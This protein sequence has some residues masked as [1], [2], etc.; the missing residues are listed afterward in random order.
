[1]INREEKR[2]FVLENK[3]SFAQF[4]EIVLKRRT[5]RDF[6]K[7][8]VYSSDILECIELGIWAPTG[9]NLQRLRFSVIIDSDLIEKIK[10]YSPGLPK[11][12][13]AILALYSYEKEE[14]KNNFYEEIINYDIGLALQNICLGLYLKGYGS[15]IVKSFNQ[16]MLDKLLY[17]KNYKLRILLAWGRIKKTP[18]PPERKE[19]KA[20]LI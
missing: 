18:L 14:Y 2:R 12:T 19:I 8:E 1:M 5:I 6:K 9:S 15:C 10:L 13:P 16:V 4:R 11:T 7:D 3:M 17:K 20:Y